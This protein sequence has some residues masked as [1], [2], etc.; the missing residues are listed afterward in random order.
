MAAERIIDF[1]V[2]HTKAFVFVHVPAIR[3]EELQMS[4]VDL[5]QRNAVAPGQRQSD[6]VHA[7]IQ[8]PAETHTEKTKLK[9][10]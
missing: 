6:S 5:P 2:Y 10:A 3:E 8:G 4:H 9:S 7:L 1:G